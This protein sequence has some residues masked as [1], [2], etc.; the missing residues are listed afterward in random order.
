M[1]YIVW[2]GQHKAEFEDL[3]SIVHTT[4]KLLPRHNWVVVRDLETIVLERSDTRERMSIKVTEAGIRKFFISFGIPSKLCKKDKFVVWRFIDE[5]GHIYEH[6]DINRFLEIIAKKFGR[7]EGES[8]LRFGKHIEIGDIKIPKTSRGI[9]ILAEKL[10]LDGMVYYKGEEFLEC[11]PLMYR[12]N[13]WYFEDPEATFPRF[14]N[15]PDLMEF[16]IKKTSSRKYTRNSRGIRIGRKTFDFT[17]EGAI[18]LFQFL[19]LEG[20]FTYKNTIHWVN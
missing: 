9:R 6:Q 13:P 4:L 1:K 3:R 14:S 17:K 8:C 11:T 12:E 5:E 2:N 10:N 19:N 15:L 20:E 18:K 16:V 7:K